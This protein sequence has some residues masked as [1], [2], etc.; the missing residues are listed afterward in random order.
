ME[1]KDIRRREGRPFDDQAELIFLTLSTSFNP[2]V[3]R[4]YQKACNHYSLLVSKRKE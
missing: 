2:V 4:T 3:A 1:A